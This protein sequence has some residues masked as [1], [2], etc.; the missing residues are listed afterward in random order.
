MFTTSTTTSLVV[1]DHTLGKEPDLANHMCVLIV[2]RGDGTLFDADS[3]LE[4]GIGELCIGMGQVHPDG[5]LWLMAVELVVA[6]QSSR[7]MLAA[8][9]LITMATVWHDDPVR[10]CTWPPTTAQI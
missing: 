4:E 2:A 7:E 1:C 3:L 10:L 8:V 5:V 9:C 6:F